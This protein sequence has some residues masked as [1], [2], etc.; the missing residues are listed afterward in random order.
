VHQWALR[1]PQAAWNWATN[2][3]PDHLEARAL[4]ELEGLNSYSVG[5]QGPGR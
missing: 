2:H 3:A 4:A 1:E 5:P